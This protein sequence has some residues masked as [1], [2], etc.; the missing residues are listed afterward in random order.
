MDYTR[1]AIVR[2]FNLGVARADRP[3]ND[4]L[5]GE[6]KRISP[7]YACLSCGGTAIEQ[8][9]GHGNSDPLVSS[10][11]DTSPSH[12]RPWCPQRRSVG[13]HADLILAHKLDT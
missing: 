12:H 3:A 10:G 2:H 8:P 5:G 9:Q 6:E 7:F 1:H 11:F 4:F 13:E